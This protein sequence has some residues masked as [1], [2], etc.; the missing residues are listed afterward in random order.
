[1]CKVSAGPVGGPYIQIIT[2]SDSNTAWGVHTGSYTVPANQTTTR[3]LFESV[4]SV[5]GASLGNFL[6]AITFTA[7]IAPPSVSEDTVTYCV[8]ETP[9]TF[10]NLVT[11]VNLKWYTTEAGGTGSSDLPVI[12]TTT[13]GTT[14]T[15][16]TQTIND[17]ESARAVVTVEVKKLCFQSN[18]FNG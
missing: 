15:Y 11:G 18:E 2:A 17:C 10:N 4:S 8:N 12:S 1:M 6:D 5:G 7:T 9:T 14:L 16:V 13:P 3:F